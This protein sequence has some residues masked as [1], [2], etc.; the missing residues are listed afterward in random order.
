MRSSYKRPV[1]QHRLA[2]SG[3][4]RATPPV[5]R[6]IARPVAMG[7]SWSSAP[8]RAAETEGIRNEAPLTTLRL[9]IAMLAHSGV[10]VAS[11]Q[12]RRRRPRSA[13]PTS[14]STCTTARI[15][16]PDEHELRRHRVRQHGVPAN[17]GLSTSPRP[18]GRRTAHD[19]PGYPRASSSRSTTRAEPGSLLTAASH[20]VVLT[21]R[22][23]RTSAVSATVNFWRGLSPRAVTRS[24]P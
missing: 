2:A 12:S 7:P 5:L 8:R 21:V 11:A 1:E 19:E 15:D 10:A 6:S 4:S 17:A 16:H 9:T 23:R 13:P 14:R 20:A 18:S 3:E 24:S 22:R